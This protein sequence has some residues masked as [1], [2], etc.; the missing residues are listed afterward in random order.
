VE[1]WLYDLARSTLSRLTLTGD[2]HSPAWSPDGTRVAFESGRGFIH[3]VFV[4]SVDGSGAERA[5]T[6]GENHHYLSDWSA[7]GR[8]LA[9]T[10]FHPETGADVWIVNAEGPPAARPFVRSVASEK[11]A[12]FSPD[13]RW[14]AYAS[15]ESGSYEVY[16]Q[17]FP[18]P[19]RRLQV[20]TRGGTEPAWSRRGHELFYRNGRQMIAVPVSPASDAPFGPSAALFEGWYHDNIAPCRSY[21]VAPDGRFL[22]ISEPVGDDLPRELQVVLGWSDDLKRRVGR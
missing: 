18:G 7:D 8:W 6:A 14:L 22:M 20:S 4:R 13:G 3:Q 17:P 21:D 15:D 11:E 16:A 10:E 9:Y 5:V 2:N 1:V 19:G 12:V